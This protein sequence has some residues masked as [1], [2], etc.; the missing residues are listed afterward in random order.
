MIKI[1]GEDRIKLLSTM[2]VEIFKSLP[3]HL[4]DTTKAATQALDIASQILEDATARTNPPQSRMRPAIA[5]A[6]EL[7]D[8]AD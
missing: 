4:W 3:E 2:S 1:T 6:K 7:Y 8:R 5:L